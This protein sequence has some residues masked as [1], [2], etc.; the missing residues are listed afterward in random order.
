MSTCKSCGAKI[1]WIETVSGKKMPCDPGLIDAVDLEEGDLLVLE[2]GETLKVRP[3][4]TVGE[5]Y[6]SHFST[7]PDADEW[8]QQEK[9]KKR[10]K[11]VLRDAEREMGV[12]EGY[13]DKD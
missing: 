3:G 12:Y 11:A 9:K 7:C 13:L 5:G 1:I 2:D 10:D 6:I 8:R 4:H